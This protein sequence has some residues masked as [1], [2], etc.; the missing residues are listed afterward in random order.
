MMIFQCVTYSRGGGIALRSTTRQGP[1]LSVLA[2]LWKKKHAAAEGDNTRRPPGPLGRTR[3]SS[4]KGAPRRELMFRPC[5]RLVSARLMSVRSM[6]VPAP[7][8]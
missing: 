2:P 3:R 7:L 1:L 6:S 8:E 5:P 4:P